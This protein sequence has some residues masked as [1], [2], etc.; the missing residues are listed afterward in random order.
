MSFIETFFFVAGIFSIGFFFLATFTSLGDGPGRLKTSGTLR[1]RGDHFFSTLEGAV[2]GTFQ[3][4]GDAAIVNN[5]DG[6]FPALFDAIAKA[7]KSINIMVFIWMRGPLGDSIFDALIERAKAGV[8]VRL[9]LDAFGC[10]LTRGAKVDELRKAGG[11]VVYFRPLKFGIIHRFHR[12]NHSRAFVFDGK[13]GFTGGM[14][15]QGRW[16]GNA[17]DPDH[18]RDMMVKVTGPMAAGIQK[19]FATLWANV[20]GEMLVG[21]KFFP[22]LP[23]EDQPRWISLISSPS[24]ESHP[25]R[26]VFAISCAAAQKSICIRN[27]YFV[28]GP[29][30]SDILQ[31]QARDGID[32]RVLV[33]DNKNDQKL[34]YHAGRYFYDE[35][36]EAGVKIYEYQPTMIH[37]KS[38]LVDDTWSVFGSANLD[39]RSHELNEENMLGIFDEKLGAEHRQDFNNDLQ[40]ARQLSL[41]EWRQRPLRNRILE[42]LCVLF[43]QQL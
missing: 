14:A 5:G 19:P 9:L 30:V 35:L 23:H 40:K 29:V 31:D 17:G 11:K 28:P 34:A 10:A 36:L 24:F 41:V 15:I 12:R 25:A 8:E 6:F 3:S 16:E 22:T 38:L 13:V 4:G 39:I 37:T 26:K 1:L 18:W 42:R 7:E 21:E 43:A 33:P 27:S 32:V 2:H 20:T